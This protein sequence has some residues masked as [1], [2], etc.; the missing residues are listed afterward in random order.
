[1]NTGLQKYK[2]SLGSGSVNQV[3]HTEWLQ[4]LVPIRDVRIKNRRPIKHTEGFR[5]SLQPVP[6]N[7]GI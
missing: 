1:M 5:V 4:F 6:A 2:R 3:V 7:S